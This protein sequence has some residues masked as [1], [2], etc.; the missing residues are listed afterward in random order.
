MDIDL[1]AAQRFL[2]ILDPMA[3]P[4]DWHY[5]AIHNI[6]GVAHK[7]DSLQGLIAKNIDNHSAYVVPNEGGDKAKDITRIRAVYVDFDKVDDHL[8]RLEQL[9]PLEPSVIVETSEG[10]HHAYWCVE[11]MP[12]EEF[13]RAQKKLIA[14]LDSD[15]VV[16]DPSRVMRL[17]GFIH[18]KHG[19]PF[20]SN[21]Y[22]EGQP[23]YSWPELQA[24]LDKL[25]EPTRE[26]KEQDWEA[27][28]QTNLHDTILKLT[29]RMAQQGIKREDIYDFMKQFLDYVQH[30][31]PVR[32]AGARAETA[33]AIEGA[34]EKY[35]PFDMPDRNPDGILLDGFTLAEEA[36]PPVYLIQGMIEEGTHGML[37]GDTGTYK[38]F[39]AFGMAHSIITGKPF[40]DHAVYRKGPVLYVPGEG[41]GGL[42][43]RWKGTMLR[44]GPV[45]KDQ[46]MV[47][48]G[49]VNLSN[50]DSMGKLLMAVQRLKPVMVILDT[51][52]S[53]AGGID[54]N[55]SGDVGKALKIIQLVCGAAGAASMTVHH[56]G[57]N[58][59]NGMRGA[60]NFKC[61]TDFV[62]ESVRDNEDGVPEDQQQVWLKSEKEKDGS[63]FKPIPIDYEVVP[64]GMFGQDGKEST[65]LVIVRGEKVRFEK[66]EQQ[67]P[68]KAAQIKAQILTQVMSHAALDKPLSKRQL[69]K[70][71]SATVGPIW[72]G[73]QGADK[74]VEAML[75]DGELHQ[76]GDRLFFFN[77]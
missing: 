70:L 53:Q 71:C 40:L 47:Y 30:I 61:D 46:F 17:P 9:F 48:K 41:G 8:D 45:G 6:T 13:T 63:P 32:A 52:A 75:R 57:K 31:D 62:I 4:H 14:L 34:L 18:N 10:K 55:H 12:L 19:V 49:G 43:R 33:R 68:D 25:P 37:A 5:R 39:I 3:G 69:R 59:A 16:H 20:L 51:F 28:T 77:H 1:D 65:T 56:W 23:S 15:P 66:P 36:K 22:H 11:G 2:S 7:V 38:S 35:A 24:E 74:I 67:K 54:E 64:L 29:A 76:Q 42:G 44:L 21:I 60:S 58:R 50:N 73:E 72:C 26:R 27:S